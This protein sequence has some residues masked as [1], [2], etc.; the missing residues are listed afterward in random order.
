MKY[1]FCC[2]TLFGLEGIVGD[3]LRYG[4]KLEDVRVENGRVLFSGD[5]RTLI[6]AN[7]W[8]RCAER[9]LL[10]VGECPAGSFSELFDGVYELPW[11]DYI[12]QN[13]AFPVKGY[14]LDSALH[15]IPDCQSIIKKAV[16]KSLSESYGTE[17]F[18]EDGARYQIQ[19]A[20]KNDVAELFL[21]TSGAGL[22][23][24]GYRANSNAAPLRETLAAA[25]VKL[26]RFKGRGEFLDPFCG[27]GTIP[28]E[29]ALIASNR[30]PGLNRS[31]DAEQWDWIEPDL[32]QQ[33]REE[34]QAAI[35]TGEFRILGSDIDP[36]CVGLSITNARKAG[37]GDLVWFTKADACRLNLRDR[38]GTLIC[39]PPYG[40]RLMDQR[41]AQELIRKFGTVAAQSPMKQYIISS[42][43][44]FE[45][46]YGVKA[47]KKRK[48]YNGMIR[49]DLHI[50]YKSP[51]E[52]VPFR[53]KP[54]PKK[55]FRNSGK[56]R[57]YRG[58]T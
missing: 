33:A 31:F 24:R 23:K 45:R 5:E 48:L 12:P 26:S 42:D 41:S 21:D 8:L 3:E 29:A 40:E 27:S 4:G 10:K 57:S 22:H 17:W 58:K 2:P 52:R 56:K 14:A 53:A 18:E 54:T 1:E 25:M 51:E 46:F 9:V 38:E 34:A 55:N 39:N 37:V 19:F 15:S 6:W 11:H 13:G 35:R 36:D 32:W 49:C 16:V 7:L 44:E 47:D 20:I 50:Y 28:I 30:A 43:G